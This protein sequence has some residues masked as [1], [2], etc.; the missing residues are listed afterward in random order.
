MSQIVY[1]NTFSP[2]ELNRAKIITKLRQAV[3]QAE[4]G[5]EQITIELNGI[6][7]VIDADAGEIL[8][9]A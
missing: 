2:E 7:I 8:V 5:A 4:S 9:I 3:S 1:E 6:E